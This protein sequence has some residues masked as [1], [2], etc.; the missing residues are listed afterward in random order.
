MYKIAISDLDG[1][2]LGA[3]H[4]IS[5]KTTQTIN[6]WIDS[7]RKF[8]IA[9]GRHYIEA[10]HLQSSINSPIYLITSNGAR[11][12]NRHGEVIHRQNLDADIAEDICRSSFAE[13]VQVNLFTDN[14]WYANYRIPELDDMGLDAGFDCIPTELA[15]L[16]KSNTIKIFFWAEPELLHPIYEQLRAQYGERINL[17]FSLSKCLEVMHATTNKGEAVKAVLADKGIKIEEA[18]AFGDGMNDVEMLNTVGKPILMENAQKAL[19]EALPNAEFTLSSKD[20]GVAVYMDKILAG[21]EYG[22]KTI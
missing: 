13:N 8:V 5:P 6:D 19:R 9:T 17:T 1:T 18:V 12:H 20:H 22:K 14:N 10:N 21:S 2:L 15:S 4:R 3:D 16:D 7:G 11:V